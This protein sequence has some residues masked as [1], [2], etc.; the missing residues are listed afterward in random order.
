[1][2]FEV[3]LFREQIPAHPKQDCQRERGRGREERGER[4]AVNK[5]IKLQNSQVWIS[6]FYKVI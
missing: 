4:E 2:E 5:Y 6:E 1:M 3:S